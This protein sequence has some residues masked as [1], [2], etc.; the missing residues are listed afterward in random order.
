[1][2]LRYDYKKNDSTKNY[3][4][5]ISNTLRLFKGWKLNPKLPAGRLLSQNSAYQKGK[6]GTL[7]TNFHL[8]KL[9]DRLRLLSTTL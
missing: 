9:K 6:E 2:E 5:K 3:Y 4:P 7:A 8:T 1:M